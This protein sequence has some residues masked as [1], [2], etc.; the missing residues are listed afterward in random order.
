MA[1]KMKN[2]PPR[3]A[4]SHQHGIFGNVG[5][6]LAELRGPHCHD[7]L[8]VGLRVLDCWATAKNSAWVL[9]ASSFKLRIL[10]PSCSAAGLACS[11]A[12]SVSA[13]RRVSFSVPLRSSS[14]W[15][16]LSPVFTFSTPI[17][18]RNCLDL[19]RFR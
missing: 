15:S 19:A 14:A 1:T 13:P 9:A 7:L 2:S 10:L 6:Q 11:M 17:T 5:L 12:S 18:S 8:E 4:Y 16:A 3:G